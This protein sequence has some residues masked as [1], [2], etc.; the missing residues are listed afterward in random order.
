M[1]LELE[2]MELELEL[3]ELELELMELRLVELELVGREL[4]RERVEVLVVGVVV[5]EVVSEVAEDAAAVW[6]EAIMPHQLSLTAKS[7]TSPDAVI[8]TCS[9]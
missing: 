4:E 5:E 1:E 3:M 8:C 6:E 7:T 9:L 2:L